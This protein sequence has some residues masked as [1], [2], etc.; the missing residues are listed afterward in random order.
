MIAYDPATLVA[1]GGCPARKQV[2]TPQQGC[3]EDREIKISG[4]CPMAINATFTVADV[5]HHQL[6]APT[7]PPAY[8]LPH[9]GS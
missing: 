5:L 6:Q 1:L 7:R 2:C 8:L 9:I 3:Y 4:W